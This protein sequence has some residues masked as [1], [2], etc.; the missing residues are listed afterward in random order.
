MISVAGVDEAGGWLYFIASPENP[1]Q[2]YL[3]RTKLDGS[4]QAERLTPADQPGTHSYD[5]SPNARL[6]DSHRTRRF[7]S[8]PTIELVTLPD[9]TAARVLVRTTRRSSSK[10]QQTLNAA[11]SRVLPRRRSATACSSTAG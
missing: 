7:G 9:H 10:A 8:P 6:G 5:I 2:L 11:S 3:Y 1:T 4:R